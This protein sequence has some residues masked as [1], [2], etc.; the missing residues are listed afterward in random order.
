MVG[1]G[2]GRCA[3]GGAGAMNIIIFGGGGFIGG[4]LAKNLSARGHRLT[5]PVRDREK[6][7]ALILLPDTDVVA[8]DPAAMGA[9]A[10]ALARADAVVNLVG[11]LNERTGGE[12]V[13]VHNEFVRVLCEHCGKRKVRRFVQISALNAG[14]AAPSEYL[15]SK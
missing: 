13:R 4:A 7:K 1:G 2:A 8:F 5:L 10:A 9:A 12:F 14:S 11:I 6:A 3:G 15:R